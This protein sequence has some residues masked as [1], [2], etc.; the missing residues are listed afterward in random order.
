MVRWTGT[1]IKALSLH[2]QIGIDGSLPTHGLM[3]RENFP[4]FALYAWALHKVGWWW[5]SMILAMYLLL[6][7]EVNVQ[8][9]DNT[10]AVLL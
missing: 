10:T 5:Y 4:F 6:Y 3:G 7:D 9:Y 2:R 8:V 1:R